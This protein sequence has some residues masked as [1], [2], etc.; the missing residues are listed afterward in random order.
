MRF[1]NPWYLLILLAIPLILWFKY[2]RKS[3]SEPRIRLSSLLL[4]QGKRT[5]LEK[6]YRPLTDILFFAALAMLIIALARPQ[7]GR[8]IQSQSNFG[9]DIILAMD[10]SASMTF[11]DTIP[12]DLPS[13]YYLGGRVFFDDDKRLLQKNR[14]NIAK[15]VIRN[16]IQN[17]TF[18]RIGIVEFASYSYT[19]SPLTLDKNMLVSI[20]NEMNISAQGQTTA[21]GM[22]ISTAINR[23]RHSQAKSKVII[24]LTDGDNNAGLIEPVTA[25]N[26]A[27]EKGM[28][29]YTIGLGNPD[30]FLQPTDGTFTRYILNSGKSVNED[31]L[32]QI[33]QITG[34]KFYRAVDEKTLKEIYEDIDQLEKT[35]I[36]VKRK[37]LYKELFPVFSL[38]GALFLLFYVSLSGLVV[39]LP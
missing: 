1:A 19:R 21:I 4:Y 17:Q 7:G 26:I 29:I 34:G 30:Q 10:T 12:A 3:W 23:L 20:I 37:V 13:R 27:R 35:Q 16:Y 31:V 11:V 28:R 38:L 33:A 9:V 25:A 15:N 24:L 2:G 36:Q 22:G 14:L 32:R 8:D 39:K 6:I 18:N 5:L